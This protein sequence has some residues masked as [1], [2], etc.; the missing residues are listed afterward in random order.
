MALSD[1]AIR[2][3]AI[4]R[5]RLVLNIALLVGLALLAARLT[6]L[7]IAPEAT[8]SNVPA[9]SGSLP[10]ADTARRS[11]PVGDLTL[12]SNLNPFLPEGQR[13]EIIDA[14][15]SD[16]EET[17][18][19]LQLV[20]TISAEQNGIANILTPKSKIAGSYQ[21]GETIIDNV[22][23]ERVFQRPRDHQDTRRAGASQSV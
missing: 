19:N 6:W 13:A 17:A 9:N 4:S 14:D 10:A 23:L 18:L 3:Q 12:L 2:R 8:L 20:G 15:V 16:V 11:A 21:V 1:P 7:V 22:T 5:L